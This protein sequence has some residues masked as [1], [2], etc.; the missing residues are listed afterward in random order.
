MTKL[1]IDHTTATR[2]YVTLASQHLRWLLRSPRH[3][4][5]GGYYRVLSE[6]RSEAIIH[7]ASAPSI[8]PHIVMVSS[9]AAMLCYTV[10]CE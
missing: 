1:F 6:N 10:L 5:V 3:H 8:Y 2:R 9:L 7:P 4:T